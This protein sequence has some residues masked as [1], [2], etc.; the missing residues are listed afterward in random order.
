MK[1]TNKLWAIAV[2][3]MLAT[4]AGIAGCQKTQTL[5]SNIGNLLKEGGTTATTYAL[6]LVSTY[7]LE[8]G[9]VDTARAVKWTHIDT[10]AQKTL[11]TPPGTIHVDT[12]ANKTN[13]TIP[14]VHID[15]GASKT[16]YGPPPG[17]THV[18]TGANKTQVRPPGGTHIDTGAN[19]TKY[20]FPYNHIDTGANKT[21]YTKPPVVPVPDTV[22][23][24]TPP[25][26]GG[27]GTVN[28]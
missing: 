19:K 12:G 26:T 20:S 9:E 14:G 4:V 24:T 25:A 13:F 1:N 28:D 18:D 21:Y 27:G 10:G 8:T 3:G 7:G 23:P 22:N 11:Y 17:Y 15:T 5:P 6:A 2:L 16:K